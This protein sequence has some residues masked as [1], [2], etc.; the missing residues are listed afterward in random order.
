MGWTTQ[1]SL[2]SPQSP[3]K[4]VDLVAH[5]PVAASLIFLPWS[6]FTSIEV[7]VDKYGYSISAESETMKS[8]APYPAASYTY[9]SS[10]G[11]HFG[12]GEITLFEGV[13]ISVT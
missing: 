2:R 9:T 6:L 1:A 12:N 4:S 10:R 11:N 8:L 13:D 3:Q 7:G 5:N